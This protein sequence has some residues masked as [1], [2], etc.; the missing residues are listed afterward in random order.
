MASRAHRRPPAANIY[1]RDIPA[2]AC[3]ID[4]G[5]M[6]IVKLA[7]GKRAVANWEG[8]EAALA[9]RELLKRS[10]KSCPVK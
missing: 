10:R 6:F 7:N 8:R 5:N 9:Q 4:N 3:V 2:S 1:W